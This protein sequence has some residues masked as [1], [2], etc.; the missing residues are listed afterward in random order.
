MVSFGSMT[1]I[2]EHLRL[3]AEAARTKGHTPI[4]Q[5]IG[6][7]FKRREA[8]E[9]Q[10]ASR[11]TIAKTALIAVIR[12]MRGHLEDATMS[13]SG[14]FIQDGQLRA[15]SAFT[16]PRQDGIIASFT[17]YGRRGVHIGIEGGKSLKIGEEHAWRFSV[18]KRELG[19]FLKDTGKRPLRD[20]V[21]LARHG[22]LFVDGEDID[23][24][25]LERVFNESV[26][27]RVTNSVVMYEGEPSEEAYADSYQHRYGVSA[28]IVRN[29]AITTEE[30]AIYGVDFLSLDGQLQVDERSI[31]DGAKMDS[32]RVAVLGMLRHR[33]PSNEVITSSIEDAAKVIDAYSVLLVSPTEQHMLEVCGATDNAIHSR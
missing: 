12:P 27:Q 14:Q 20:S 2:P 25:I 24:K 3:R 15:G 6:D 31:A 26:A 5:G 8:A 32:E 33:Y 22:S 18:P 17:L 16:P 13:L 9:L 28:T 7:P 30:D 11:L 4:D 10:R 19:T 29:P 21:H 1:E 23:T